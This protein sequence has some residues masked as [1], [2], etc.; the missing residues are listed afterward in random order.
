MKQKKKVRPSKRKS[1]DL[2]QAKSS[3][4]KWM[5]IICGCFA[6]LLYANT[7][8]HQFALDDFTTIYGNSLTTSGIK[9]IPMLLHT[10]YWYGIDS[11]NDWLYRPFSMVMFA[12]EWQ[13]APNTPALGHWIN[14]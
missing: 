2:L 9:G 7:L 5:G 11:K 6:F 1:Q 14:V 13:L 3:L 10:A 8:N 4:Q 12:L